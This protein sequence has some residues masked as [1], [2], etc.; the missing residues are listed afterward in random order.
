MI[1]IITDFKTVQAQID[2]IPDPKHIWWDITRIVVT[3]GIDMPPV[4]TE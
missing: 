2:A 3:T 1:T 4:V